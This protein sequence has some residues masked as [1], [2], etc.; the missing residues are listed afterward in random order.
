MATIAARRDGH[1]SAGAVE[2]ARW[3]PNATNCDA[4]SVDRQRA[5]VPRAQR[6][7]NTPRPLVAVLHASPSPDASGSAR[8]RPRCRGSLR[9]AAAG[10]PQAS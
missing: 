8:A 7:T 3:S 10:T 6:S 1:A 5:P 4:A 9:V 2:V